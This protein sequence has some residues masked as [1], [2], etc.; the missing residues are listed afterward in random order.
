MAPPR[1]FGRSLL[2]RRREGRCE[3]WRRRI[4]RSNGQPSL[5]SSWIETSRLT[6]PVMHVFLP[7]QLQ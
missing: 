3:V 6:Q 4:A 7:P 1:V 5:L 2:L